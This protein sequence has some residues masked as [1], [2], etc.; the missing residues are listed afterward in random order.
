MTLPRM[1]TLISNQDFHYIDHLAP[2]SSLLDIPIV[3][4]DERIEEALKTFYP[5]V[6]TLI[7]S[8]IE[9]THYLVSHFEMIFTCLPTP[10]F[11]ELVYPAELLNEKRLINVWCPHGNSDKGYRSRFMEELREERVALVYGE[12]MIH[13]LSEKGS[14][15]QLE[16][17]IVTGNYRYRYYLERKNFLD[18]KC[19][20]LFSMDKNP[21]VLYAP[22]WNDCENNSSFE[23]ISDLLMRA[24]PDNLN[25]IIKLHPNTFSS[26]ELLDVYRLTHIKKENVLILPEFPPIYPIL[27]AV[28]FYLGDMSSIGYDFLTFRK[29]MFFLNINERD[30]KRDPGLYLTQC[31]T[32][33]EP[34]DFENIYSII[35][36]TDYSSF[37]SRQKALYETV[38]G[39][40]EKI[41]EK[42]TEFYEQSAL[43]S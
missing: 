42:V 26:P 20:S 7:F 30:P 15:Q 19:R 10:L 43:S 18:D 39:K 41:K 23:L 9:L 22:T 36:T 33:I 3:L 16:K 40:E 11:K 5:E 13:F 12:K 28:D 32:L 31:G 27:N 34:K 21:T 29:P 24:L 8:P 38:F 17:V 1:A 35:Q 6:K 4:S 37:T 25:L 14:Y 2:L